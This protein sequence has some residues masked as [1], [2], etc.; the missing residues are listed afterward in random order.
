MRYVEGSVTLCRD[1]YGYPFANPQGI[2][3]RYPGV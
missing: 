3:E 1:R 2:L